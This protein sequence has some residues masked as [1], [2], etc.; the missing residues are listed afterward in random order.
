M[1]PNRSVAA[2]G[3]VVAGVMCLPAHAHGK[4]EPKPPTCESLRLASLQ[5]TLIT[6]AEVVPAGTFTPPTGAAQQNLPEFCRIAGQIRN[7]PTSR[8][9][10]EVWLPTTIPNKRFVQV[11][12]GGFAGSIQYG[13]MATRLREGYATA[14]TDDG[15]TAPPGVPA[16]Q[17][18]TFLGDFERLYDFKGRAVTL[19]ADVAQT[20]FEKFYG[21]DPK[22]S[23][24]TGC[25][26]GG[27][28][29]LAVAQR[30][31]S[32]FDGISAGSPANNS[33]GLFTQAIWTSQNYQQIST[34][35]GLIHEAALAACDN[36]GDGINDGVIGNPEH[37]HFDPGVLQCAAGDAPTCLTPDQV[38]A[39]RK[40]YRG[41]V[42]PATGTKTGE[43]YAP[44]M[45]RGSELQWN[46]APGQAS[47]ASQPWYGMVLQGTLT[48]DLNA[49]DFENDVAQALYLTKPYGAQVTNPDLSR[50]KH[51]GGKM[52]MWAGW[53]D[54]LWSER[55]LVN[56]YKQVVAEERHGPHGRPDSAAPYHVPALDP[57]ALEETQRYA[58]LFMAPG[59]GHCGGGEGPNNFD[60]FPPLVDWVERGK[61]PKQILA[62]KFVN[63]QAS[64]GVEAVRPICAYPAVARWDGRGDPA[65]AESFKCVAP[66]L[67]DHHAPGP[68][69]HGHDHHDRDHHDGPHW[70]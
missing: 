12:N 44:G 53:N 38:A 13:A 52:L 47:G 70:R 35:L 66:P 37:C 27:L 58:R 15:T 30:I 61:A 56:Y 8:I 29:A 42:N 49:F 51:H 16:N 23:Y 22:Y 68:G 20:L 41:P 65:L 48:F 18:L 60:T 43:E 24:F 63:N 57:R 25:S 67:G 28:E 54:Q 7:H 39:A 31:G 36:V 11:G 4:P 5:D 17:R 19:T 6:T 26:T 46:A 34:K 2:L 55:N 64:Q 33:A 69:H 32:K 21:K 1:S 14:S 50:F 40:I 62:T 3:A 9:M 10:F 45:P 59:V